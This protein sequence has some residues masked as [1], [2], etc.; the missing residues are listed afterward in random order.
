[1]IG[2]VF[3]ATT[4]NYM[5]R[6][7]LSVVAPV[8]RDEFH[9]SD[10]SYA[11]IVSA[12]M[13]AYTVMNGVSGPLI[14]R[15]GTRLGYSL[16]VAWWSAAAMLHAVANGPGG[17]GVCRFC[18]AWVRQATGPPGFVW[19][20]SGFPCARGRLRQESSIAARPSEL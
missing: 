16:C 3:W 2:L 18:W 9:M 19:S 15:L 6:Q 7:T 11:R 20:P 8:L 13:L 17:F 1:M 14:D 4:I 10:L 5:D 12:F